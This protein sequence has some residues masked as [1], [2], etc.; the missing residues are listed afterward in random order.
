MEKAT[1][2]ETSLVLRFKSKAY[3]DLVT[4]GKDF[5]GNLGDAMTAMLNITNSEG[6]IYQDVSGGTSGEDGYKI[7][8]DVG[9]KDLNK[10]M[11]LNFTVNGK[12]YTSELVKKD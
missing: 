12:K 2:T 8:F 1:L 3:R 7:T 6:K 5:E 10:K 9:K 4:A 11:F